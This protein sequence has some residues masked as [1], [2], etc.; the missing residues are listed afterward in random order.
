M[1]QLVLSA[2]NWPFALGICRMTGG[3][4]TIKDLYGSG[5][6]HICHLHLLAAKPFF[7]AQS[8]RLERVKVAICEMKKN[9]TTLLVHGAI[10]E[11]CWLR[12]ASLGKNLE[13]LLSH[14]V[15]HLL[16]LCLVFL[17]DVVPAGVG[18]VVLAVGG[19]AT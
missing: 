18:G 10:D 15:A 11:T 16:G 13:C 7:R 5:E 12:R 19:Q 2:H 8:D 14:E 4:P 3:S 1:E 6:G 9:S 17:R